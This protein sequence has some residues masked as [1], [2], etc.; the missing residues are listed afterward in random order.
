MAGFAAAKLVEELLG[1]YFEDLDDVMLDIFQGHLLLQ[2]IEVRPRAIQSA[3]DL[4]LVVKAGTIGRV[5]LRIPWAKLNSE[6]T[7]LILDDLFILCGPQS[8]AAWDAEA[9]EER[10]FQRKQATLASRERQPAV[11]DEV[12]AKE[13]FQT[14]L[15]QAV[16]QRLQARPRPPAPPRARP[17]A[18]AGQLHH[19]HQRCQLWSRL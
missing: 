17:E 8:E 5:E 16:L 6:P 12:Q 3:L 18:G 7:Q 1:D 19:R 9:E 2:N 13:T 14:R 4:P 10:A 11:H 15:T